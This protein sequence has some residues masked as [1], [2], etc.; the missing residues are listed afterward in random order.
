M[1][2]QAFGAFV[3]DISKPQGSSVHVEQVGDE[4][5]L[6]WRAKWFTAGGCY[7]FAV[8][9]GLPAVCVFLIVTAPRAPT[10]DDILYRIW[11]PAMLIP[12]GVCYY[13]LRWILG[14]ER[15]RIGPDGLDYQSRALIP[16]QERHV[17]LGEIKGIDYSL[18][19]ET[20]GKPIR[21]WQDIEPRERRRLADLL[22]R[23]L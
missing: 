21:F 23:H 6:R 20:L 8:F 1:D 11:Y 13:P 18:K 4:L 22:Q 17:P 10:L 19:I 15:L 12:L 16:L 9:L 5:V 2:P 7:W 14:T 3:M